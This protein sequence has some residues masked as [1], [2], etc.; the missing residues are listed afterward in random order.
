MAEIIQN[1]ILQLG[2]SQDTRMPAALDGDFARVDERTPDSLYAFVRS[3]AGSVNYYSKNTSATSEVWTNFFPDVP[4][5]GPDAPPHLALLQAFFEL[6][7]L[8]QGVLNQF[9]GRHLDFYYREVL[10]LSRKA[11]VPDKVHVLFELKKQALPISISSANE[12]SAGKDKTGVEL[13][14]TPTGQTIINTSAVDS[15]RS[16]YIDSS[17]KVLYAPIANSDDGVGAPLPPA[18][19]KWAGFGQPGLP[20]AEVG[21]AIASPVL[22]MKEGDR[23]ITLTLTLGSFNSQKLTSDSLHGAFEA[24]VTGEK[25]WVS[26]EQTSLVMNGS[27]AL[28]ITFHVPSSEKGAVVDYSPAVHGYSYAAEAPILQLLLN[29]DALAYSYLKGVVLQSA[30]L[31]VTAKNLTSLDLENDA[32]VL[33]PKK[34]FLPF[35]PQP[36]KG[37][38]FYV[39]CDEALSKKLSELDL[40]VTWHG[41]QNDFKDYY[42]EYT[43]SP[44][45]SNQYFTAIASFDDGSDSNGSKTT[46]S[47]FN[48]DDA[49]AQ[50]TFSLIPAITRSFS[51]WDIP[52]ARLRAYALSGTAW[53]QTAAREYMLIRPISRSS[54]SAIPDPRTGF[55]TFS[56]VD[57][58]LHSEYRQQYV[59]AVLASAT[60]KT[61]PAMP[62][63]PYTS[64][65]QSIVLNYSAKTDDVPITSIN[66]DDY[67]NPDIQFF[68]VAYFGQ[69]REHGYQRAQFDFL[70]QDG[71]VRLL[72]TYDFEGALLIGFTGLKPNDSVSVL[73][74]VAEG[75][76]D[77]DLDPETIHWFVLCDNYWRPLGNE[78][79]FL[80]TT[81]QLLTSGI[82]QFVIPAAATTQ[83]TILPADHIWIKGAVDEN[84]EAVCQL[85]DVRANAVEAQFSDNGNDPNHLQTALP[86][87]SIAKLKNALSAVKTVSQPYGSFGGSPAESDTAFN[88][89]VAERLRHKDRCITPWDYERIVLEAFPNVHKVKCIPHASKDSWLAPG[90]VTIVV[91]PDLKNQ[92]AVDILRPR[93]D[94]NTISRITG[95]VEKRAWG[96]NRVANQ[97]CIHVKNPSYQ[98]VQLDFKVQFRDG[99]EFNFYS[100]QLDQ[101]LIEYLSPWAFPSHPEDISFGGRIYKS[102]LLAFVEHVAYVNFVTDFKLHS[103]T[104][105][106][107]SSADLDEVQPE[108]PDAILVSSDSHL[109]SQYLEPAA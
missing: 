19:P 38:L 20:A 61:S 24:F 77:P 22:R 11:P 5:P 59:K 10:R 69:M 84:V 76:A 70:N 8:P 78:E 80:D 109:I 96:Q 64:A 41:A 47:L 62:N 72:P 50:A 29:Q 60:G 52:S 106:S 7:Q 48:Q 34:T 55:I 21:F 102:V 28:Q 65:I 75:S 74:Q 2:Q 25:K 94:A 87:G 14:Y 98:R 67:A 37:S 104:E 95:V 66:P 57:D 26:L 68:H 63:E 31:A 13:I 85:I 108:R 103:F 16:V 105:G 27:G 56:L 12:L 107:S 71:V 45:T 79:V 30:Q 33:N 36:V 92:N 53:G 17:G 91:V 15:L 40:V 46:V 42:K 93:V 3:L 86:A 73:F 18:S 6:Y 23:S 81:N 99:Y 101:Q 83:N 58:F 89:R 35:G 32:G 44:V 82:I 4:P 39:G 49:T 90:H 43:G 54:L 9:T 100:R 51:Q 88:T 1:M 97:P